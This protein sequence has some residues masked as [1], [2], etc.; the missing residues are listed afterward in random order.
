MTDALQPLDGSV[1]GALKAHARRLFRLRAR[2]NPILQRTKQDA[3]QDMAAARDLL[4]PTALVPGWEIYEGE[5][6]GCPFNEHHSIVRLDFSLFPVGCCVRA[7]SPPVP[8]SPS[9]SGEDRVR[10][11]MRIA[12]FR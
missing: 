9:V 5:P 6:W 10:A 7:Y 2:D 8:C 1:F 4:S 3:A 11:Y 12:V